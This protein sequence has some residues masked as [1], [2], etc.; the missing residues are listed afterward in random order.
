MAGVGERAI[1]IESTL[2]FADAVDRRAPG[3][4][5]T[6]ALCG[7]WEH[8]GQC[9]WP[10]NNRLVGLDS[11]TAVVRTVAIVDRADLGEVHRRVEVGL[12]GDPRWSLLTCNQQ[13]LTPEER[14]LADRLARGSPIL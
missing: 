13:E 4:V 5:V 6:T 12:G 7:H 1:V 14:A 9:R 11:S 10:H 2:E 3:G 8:D